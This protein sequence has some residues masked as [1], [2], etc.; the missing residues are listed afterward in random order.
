MKGSFWRVVDAVDAATSIL[1]TAMVEIAV[2]RNAVKKIGIGR[3]ST[4]AVESPST[5]RSRSV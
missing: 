4:L 2:Q 3:K 1:V 5:L